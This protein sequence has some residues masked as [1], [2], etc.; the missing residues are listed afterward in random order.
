MSV[1]VKPGQVWRYRKGTYLEQAVRTIVAVDSYGDVNT[2]EGGWCTTVAFLLENATLVSDAPEQAAWQI[3]RPYNARLNMFRALKG[4][5]DKVFE[6]ID[7]SDFTPQVLDRCSPFPYNPF[8]M[9]PSP[10]PAFTCADC[11][12]AGEFPERVVQARF[13][14]GGPS[15]QRLRTCDPCMAEREGRIHDKQD[16][17]DERKAAGLCC[18]EPTDLRGFGGPWPERRYSSEAREIQLRGRR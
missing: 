1:E 14:V 16:R 17:H 8:P 7:C 11:G 13:T 9:A 2:V 15:P 18:P 4:P 6:D 3:P 5:I 12:A 10:E